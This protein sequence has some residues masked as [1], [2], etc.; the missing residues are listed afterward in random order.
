MVA[1]PNSEHDAAVGQ[2]IGDREILG[3]AQRMP[4]RRDIEAGMELQP[5]RE[6]RQMHRQHNDIWQAFGA[7]RLEMVLRHPER[8]IPQPVHRLRLGLGLVVSGDE[9]L[10]AVMPGINR[11]AEVTYIFQVDVT[12]IGTIELGDHGASSGATSPSKPLSSM[13]LRLTGMATPEEPGALCRARRNMTR[14]DKT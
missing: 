1:A 14:H 7:F 4:H 12:R 9:L 5:L 8:P 2:D 10:V 11:R 13:V 6:V 3:E